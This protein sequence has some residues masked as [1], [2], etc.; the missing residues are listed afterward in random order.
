MFYGSCINECNDGCVQVSKVNDDQMFAHIVANA[1]RSHSISPPSHLPELNNALQG[2][3]CEF[4]IWDIGDRLW[5]IYSRT[6]TWPSNADSPWRP[7]SD[8]GIDI[9]AIASANDSLSLIIVAAKSSQH[10]GHNLIIG[11]SSTLQSDFCHLFAGDIQSRL[12][13]R[14]GD[15]L[16]ELKIRRSLPD[17]AKKIECLVGATPAESPNVKLIGVLLCSRESDLAYQRRINAFKQLRTYL[18]TQGWCD[19]QMEFRC[20]EVSNFSQWIT[21]L[22]RRSIHGSP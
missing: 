12:L 3:L 18:H 17:L 11:N 4:C 7:S 15:I 5:H 19:K 14:V 16:F 9:L 10:S 20:I 13:A 1:L 8:P 22:M 6:D 2:N 21:E